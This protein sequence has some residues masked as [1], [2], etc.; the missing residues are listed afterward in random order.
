MLAAMPRRMEG[1]PVICDKCQFKR[2]STCAVTR[3][4][5]EEYVK[6]CYMKNFVEEDK[7]GGLFK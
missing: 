7:K 4:S 3:L 1:S 5:C 6:Y 2:G